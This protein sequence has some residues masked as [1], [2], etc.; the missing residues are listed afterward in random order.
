MNFHSESV[1]LKLLPI[2]FSPVG[3]VTC[4][5]FKISYISLD[6]LFVHI[7]FDILWDMGSIYVTILSK[8]CFFL[9]SDFIACTVPVHA[10]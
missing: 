9:K 8:L 2:C 4:T 10:R 6:S 5:L 1:I 7:Y 3:F